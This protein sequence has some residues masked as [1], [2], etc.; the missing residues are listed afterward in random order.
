MVL[1]YSVEDRCMLT[2]FVPHAEREHR[3]VTLAKRAEYFTSETYAWPG[4]LPTIVDKM[5]PDDKG[6]KFEMVAT[7]SG[8]LGKDIGV[9]N[10][11][12][13]PRDRWLQE[14]AKSKFMVSPRFPRKRGGMDLAD[15]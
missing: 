1:G 6:N 10:I 11:G 13:F 15:E 14:V 3:G 9:R 8:T 4:F 5:P 12:Q 7:A 2:P